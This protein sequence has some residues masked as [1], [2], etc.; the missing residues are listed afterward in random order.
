[1]AQRRK[2]LNQSAQ[3]RVTISIADAA[4]LDLPS[5]PMGDENYRLRSL[6]VAEAAIHVCPCEAGLI[7]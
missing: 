2:W 7:P 5:A 4:F 3:R 6:Y 1:M